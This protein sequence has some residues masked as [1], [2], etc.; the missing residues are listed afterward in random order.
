MSKEDLLTIIDFGST[1][2]RLGVFNK[3][4]SNQKFILEEECHN[5][6]NNQYFETEKTEKL[7]Q[8]MIYKAEKNFD[9]HLTS[10]F[11]MLDTK[12]LLSLDISVKKNTDSSKN[13]NEEIEYLIKDSKNLIEKNNQSKK[14]IHI[15]VSKFII[16]EKEYFDLPENILDFKSIIL[17][18]KF[19]LIPSILLNKITKM[20]KNIQLS[21]SN[22]FLFYI[23]QII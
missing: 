3:N 10:I 21:I 12:D 11:L 14:N 16:D 6:F 19:I 1:K 13:L 9:K 18:L 4:L 23:C 17:D 22:F 2:I 8:N 5:D 15:I 7:I 20:F